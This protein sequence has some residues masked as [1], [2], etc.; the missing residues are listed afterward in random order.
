MYTYTYI[1]IYIIGVYVCIYIYI[2]LHIYIYIYVFRAVKVAHHASGDST[3]ISPTIISNK[4][5]EFQK[6]TWISPLW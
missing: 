2:Y 3:M 1:Y 6:R 5:F 4:T